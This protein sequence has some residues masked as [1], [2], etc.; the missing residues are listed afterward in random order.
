M[1]NWLIDARAG[2]NDNVKWIMQKYPII[3]K[4]SMA[5]PPKRPIYPT[6]KTWERKSCKLK[7]SSGYHKLFQTFKRSFV[8]GMEDLADESLQKEL[9]L[10]EGLIEQKSQNFDKKSV[11]D[12]QFVQE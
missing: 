9:T 3:M 5:F 6:I 1:K 11:D 4:R 10:L 8:K 12:W 2:C 7:V